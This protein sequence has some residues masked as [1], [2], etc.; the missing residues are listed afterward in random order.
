MDHHDCDKCQCPASMD[1]DNHH[2][3]NTWGWDGMGWDGMGSDCRPLA[4]EVPRQPNNIGVLLV[5]PPESLGLSRL[6]V[7]D[8]ENSPP[9]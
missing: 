7:R 5:G 3:H 6:G 8:P 4:L 9:P 2:H 1:G